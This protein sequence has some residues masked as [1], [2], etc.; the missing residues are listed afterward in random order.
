M[1]SDN[2]INID[3]SAKINADFAPLINATPRGVGRLFSY[4]FG[5]REAEN[6][7]NAILMAAKTQVEYEMILSGEYLYEDG[8][9]IPSPYFASRENLNPLQIESRKELQNLAGNVRM[10][11]EALR[12]VPDKEISDKPVDDD[13]I[14]RWR[15]EAKVIGN[16]EL[17]RLWGR[18]LAE[19]VSEPESIS[20]RTL[21]VVKNISS[22]EANCFRKAATLLVLDRVLP[23]NINMNLFSEYLSL[24]DMLML[25]SAGLLTA[26]SPGLVVDFPSQGNIEGKHNFTLLMKNTLLPV[27]ANT[28]VLHIP[29]VMLSDVG[30]QIAAICD[31]ENPDIKDFEFV[32]KVLNSAEPTRIFSARALRTNVKEK[33]NWRQLFA[34]DYK[35]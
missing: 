21:D 24:D 27:T 6:L 15:R 12:D 34:W 11:V 2:P 20:L 3:L 13:F 7:R 28:S 4:F 5:D 26:P 9:L 29:G 17:Q 23:C 1:A 30:K 16:E 31:C 35:L 19:E 8:K 33:D 22:K 14:A 18:L 10:A 32:I 25:N